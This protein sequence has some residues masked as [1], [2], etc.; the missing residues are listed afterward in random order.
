[1]TFPAVRA[2]DDL[3]WLRLACDLA[4][5]CPPS[6]TAFSVGAVVVDARGAEIARGFSRADDPHDHAEEAALAALAR[7][8]GGAAAADL[9][10]LPGT[11]LAGATIYTSLEPCGERSSRPLPCGDLIAAAG[12]GR[13]VFAWREPPLFVRDPGGGTDRLR[14]HGV[15]VVELPELADRARAPNAHLL[16]QP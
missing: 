2:V 6:R 15:E 10:A 5:R 3:R 4:R 11:G 1:M 8:H 16:G 9:P 14:A 12:V 13:V 7:R